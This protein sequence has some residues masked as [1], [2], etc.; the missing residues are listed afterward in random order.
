MRKF[1]EQ[2]TKY[3]NKQRRRPEE[4]TIGNKFLIKHTKEQQPSFLDQQYAGLYTV[5]NVIEENTCELG[6]NDGW[7]E[8]EK[9]YN[10]KLLENFCF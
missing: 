5:N 4:L 3:M 2:T 10:R 9:I 8:P 7:T 6:I 1:N